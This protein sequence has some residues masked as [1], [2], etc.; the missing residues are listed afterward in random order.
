MRYWFR[1][2]RKKDWLLLFSESSIGF[3]EFRTTPVNCP[4]PISGKAHHRR[5]VTLTWYLVNIENRHP[6]HDHNL[7]YHEFVHKLDMLDGIAD[8]TP[9]FNYF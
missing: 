8:G 5:P 1:D 4:I 2:Y 3:F 7:V 6:E 9:I